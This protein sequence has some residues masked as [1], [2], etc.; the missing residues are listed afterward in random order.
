MPYG[1]EEIL[2]LVIGGLIVLIAWEV[3]YFWKKLKER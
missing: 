1:I 3:W 2:I